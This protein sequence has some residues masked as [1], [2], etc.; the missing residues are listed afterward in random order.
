[1]STTIQFKINGMHCSACAM[2]ID[3]ELEDTQGVV[4]SNTNYA[5]QT[6]EVEFDSEKIDPSQIIEI[7]NRV[8]YSVDHP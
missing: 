7:I 8:G 6:T 1:M 3:G 4:Q 5:R 2:D